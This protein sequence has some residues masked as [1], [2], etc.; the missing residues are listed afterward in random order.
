[1]RIINV[2]VENFRG[3]KKGSFTFPVDTRLV[4]VIGPGDSS[5]STLLKSIEW[6]LWPSWNLNVTD[7]DFYNGDTRVPIKI[8][9]SIAEFADV[10]YSED[11]YGL[12]LRNAD[13]VVNHEQNDE[14]KEN[15]MMALTVRLTIDECLEPKWEVVTNRLEPKVINSRDRQLLQC[16]SI[17]F[18]YEKD[19]TWGR[20]SILQKYTDSKETL[21]NTYTQAI[22]NVAKEIQLNNLDAV[23]TNLMHAG[24]QYGVDFSGDLHNKILMQNGSFATTVGIFDGNVPFVQRGLGS[25]RL[26]SIGM[27]VN[28]SDGASVL[29]IDEIETGLEPYRICSLINEFR[30]RYKTSGQII[31]TTHSQNAVTECSIKELQIIS[32]Q[33]GIVQLHTLMTDDS[34]MNDTIQKILRSQPTAFL[35]KRIIVCEGSTEIGLL[36]ALDKYMVENKSERFAYYGVCTA[37]AG[38][39]DKFFKMAYLLKQCG[40][41]T[42]IVMDSDIIDE[43]KDKSKYRNVYGIKIFDWDVGNAIE[44]QLFLDSSLEVINKLIDV[45]V[46]EKS[47]DHVKEKFKGKISQDFW[48][49]TDD[50]ISIIGDIPVAVKKTIGTIAKDKNSEWFKRID[51]GEKVGDIVFSNYDKYDDR[52]RIKTILS[53][54]EKWVTRN[55][56]I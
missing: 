28:A 33:D 22:R 3:I 26:L 44:E 12:Y 53:Q 41:D 5:K 24:K 21:H 48:K 50:K 49:I 36:R 25:K 7:N 47:L 16:N 9:V 11:K 52:S 46:N 6:A 40:Y 4:C 8:E 42:C 20:N 18:N 39:G 34:K 37:T 29:L 14:P 30:R 10:L 32:S 43:E 17:G 1:M 56:T 15:E 45:V 38:G 54:I 13:S 27:N 51:L 31:M 55:E 19:F 2:D 23:T 35:C